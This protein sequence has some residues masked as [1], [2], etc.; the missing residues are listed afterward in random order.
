[1]AMGVKHTTWT[2]EV[3]QDIMMAMFETIQRNPGQL[4]AVVLTLQEKGHAFSASA[5]KYASLLCLANTPYLAVT[6]A[7]RIPHFP[8]H[9]LN[10]TLQSLST[11]LI[12]KT[13]PFIH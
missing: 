9:L 6:I 2:E 10:S 7:S 12:S 3:H 8:Y 1:M 11:C 5:L 4:A 13:A